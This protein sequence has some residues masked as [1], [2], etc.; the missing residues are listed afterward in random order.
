MNLEHWL[1]KNIGFEN[2]R[3]GLWRIQ[4]ALKLFELD[5]SDKK[6]VAVAGTN[7]KGQT[8]RELYKLCLEESSCALWTSPHLVSVTERFSK[9]GK[10]IASQ[11]LEELCARA[12]FRL[13]KAEL[14]LSYYEFLF[15]AFL[16]FS[17]NE[18]ILV[19]EAGLGGRLDAVNALK[20]DLVL[21]TSISRDHQ[22]ILGNRFDLILGEKIALAQDGAEL[23]TNFELKYLR[24][25]T[26]AWCQEHGVQWTDLFEKGSCDKSFNFERRNKVLAFF[27]FCKI[28]NKE[29]C[30]PRFSSEGLLTFSFE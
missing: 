1:E 21:L 10:E 27:G 19:L 22:E 13:R 3:P 4:K 18:R 20:A 7:G 17:R 23:A 15:L 24:Q 9:N 5:F 6:I 26:R 29:F 14:E 11:E 12:M 8:A 28:F 16:L 25:K 30:S 2:F